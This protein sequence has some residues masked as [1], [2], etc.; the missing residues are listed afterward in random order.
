MYSVMFGYNMVV[1][2][3]WCLLWMPATVLYR[4]YE[5]LSYAWIQHGCLANMVNALDPSNSVI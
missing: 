1:K 5:A 3:T 2:L 4:G